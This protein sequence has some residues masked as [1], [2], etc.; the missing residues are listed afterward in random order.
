[1]RS[2]P[3]DFD[4]QA[5]ADIDGLLDN[6][7]RDN[8]VSIPL[9]IESG[10]RAWG[11]P[12]PDSDY[13]CRFIYV[14]TPDQYLSPWTPR[15]V[16]ETPLIGLMDLNGWDLG[17]ALKLMLKGNAVVVEWLRSPIVYCGDAEFKSGL[18]ALAERH[19]DRASIARHYLH[20]GL[21]QRNT[22]FSDGKAVALK[23][24]FYALRPAA[25][26]RWMRLHPDAPLPPM[27][28]PTL[29]AES[30]PDRDVAAIV[31]ELLARKADTNELGEGPLPEPVKA[32]IDAEFALAADVFE[33]KPYRLTP[34]AKADADAF[35]G[36]WVGRAC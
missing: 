30:E 26:L 22:Y 17:K 31:G 20:L 35:F 18:L 2:V 13:D 19:C 14:R 9:A 24:I 21:R 25:A 6:V 3:V 28:F 10:S 29:L 27:H 32:F 7:M 33:G 11:F 4:S 23:K 12:S 1:M 8:R 16:I 5:L 36:A 34:Q 15:D